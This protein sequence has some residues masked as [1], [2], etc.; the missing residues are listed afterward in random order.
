MGSPRVWRKMMGFSFLVELVGFCPGSPKLCNVRMI[1]ENGFP[2]PRYP[3]LMA[4]ST[5]RFLC[6]IRRK[7]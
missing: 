6:Q 3:G 7:K 2:L 5:S 4:T 1:K